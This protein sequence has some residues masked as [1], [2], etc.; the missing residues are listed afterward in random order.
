MGKILYP[1]LFFF[2]FISCKEQN[3]PG[4][5]DEQRLLNRTPGEWLS[6]GGNHLMQH[7]SPLTDINI[8]T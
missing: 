2:S 7:Y 1:L 6:L 3:P 5:I 4:W 8:K